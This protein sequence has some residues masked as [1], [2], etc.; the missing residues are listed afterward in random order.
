MR[1]NKRGRRLAVCVTVFF[2]SAAAAMTVWAR[3]RPDTVTGVHWKEDENGNKKTEAVWEPVE[4][5]YA[6]EIQLYRDEKRQGEPIEVKKNKTSYN[7]RRKMVKEG[8]YMF[9]VRAT[10]KKVDR[11][12][13]D[14]YWS[15]ESDEL[16]VNETHAENNQNTTEQPENGGPGVIRQGVWQQDETGWRYCREDGS[17]P[18]DS[19]FQD[20]ADQ[21]Y[22]WFDS[23]GYMKTGW[24]DWE[25]KWYYCD[26]AGSPSGA[27]VTGEQVIDGN[28]Y[29][30]DE[31][32]ALK[33]DTDLP[34]GS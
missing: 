2:L 8:T 21:K 6:Y 29:F 15:E 16:Y 23:Q 19:W 10:V 34:F 28:Q 22:Y 7:L 33:A 32:G 5:A 31:S 25:G 12:N 3:T 30:F 27:M 17:Y 18:K 20:P 9:K 1:Q 26:L 11:E 24:I 4:G 13:A 14:G